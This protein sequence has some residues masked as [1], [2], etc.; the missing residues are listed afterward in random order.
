MTREILSGTA[1]ILASN[2]DPDV[3]PADEETARDDGLFSEVAWALT[4]TL[5]EFS[6]D[7]T[8][9]GHET[10][11]IDNIRSRVPAK[12]EKVGVF[13]SHPIPLTLEVP[14]LVA[15]DDGEQVVIDWKAFVAL[16]DKTQRL[17]AARERALAVSAQRRAEANPD[18]FA[19]LRAQ[20]K[21]AV[22]TWAEHVRRGSMTRKQFDESSLVLVRL[23]HMDRSDYDAAVAGL[24]APGSDAP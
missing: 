24:D 9:P 5:Y 14:V 12:A 17:L 11:Q 3:D 2:R 13:A 23:G 16:P 10:Y 1:M 15:S 20:N 21:Q 7:V 8:L 6:L 18:Q 22:A 4:G 19:A